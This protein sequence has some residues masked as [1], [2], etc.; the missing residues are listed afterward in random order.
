MLEVLAHRNLPLRHLN[1]LH[2]IRLGVPRRWL[3]GRLGVTVRQ[4][5]ETLLG[6]FKATGAEVLDVEPEHLDLANRCYT[7]IVRAEAAFVHRAALATKPDG[8]SSLVRPALESGA[9]ITATEYL[10]ARAE[11]RLVRSGLE[12]ILR[13]VDALVLPAAPLAAPLRGKAEVPL[14]SGM[15]AHRNAFI[16][17]TVP[18]S[19]VGLPTLS[20]PFARESGLPVGL[21]IVAARGDDATALELG[22]WLERVMES[23]HA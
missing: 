15:R 5:F 13:G 7:P 18:F 12:E 14:E 16:E 3:E 11:R 23:A 17:L 8:F 20:I 21:Q 6:Q 1:S 22:W 2:G 4:D 19:L 10:Q 9:Q